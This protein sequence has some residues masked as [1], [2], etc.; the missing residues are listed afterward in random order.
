MNVFMPMRIIESSAALKRVAGE[1]IITLV[2]HS[3]QLTRHDTLWLVVN[4]SAEKEIKRIS[5]TYKEVCDVK[6]IA[7]PFLT[8]GP[9][10]TVMTGLSRFTDEELKRKVVCID[11]DSLHQD[12]IL[13]LFRKEKTDNMLFY[14][15]TQS[16]KYSYITLDEKVAASGKATV[17]N[18][19]EKDPISN[20]ALSG[21][22]AFKSARLL[23]EY[24][25][26]SIERDQLWISQLCQLM[27][28]DGHT[29]RGRPVTHF[30]D[31]ALPEQRESFAQ[32]LAEGANIIP[33]PLKIAVRLESLL[34][35]DYDADLSDA[36]PNHT[37][38]AKVQKLKAMGHSIVIITGRKQSTDM[39]KTIA[40]GNLTLEQIK[41]FKIPFDEI[42][43]GQPSFDMLLTS[44]DTMSDLGIEFDLKQPHD[45]VKPRSFN[46]VD[47][48]SE[49]AVQKT[50]KST[51]LDGEVHFYRN[52]PSD[53]IGYF[54]K[55]IESRSNGLYT[56]L[57]MSRVQGTP[58]TNLCISHCFSKRHLNMLL[59]ALRDIH[60]SKA[61]VALSKDKKVNVYVNY[62]SKVRKRF[63]EHRELY[64]QLY[65]QQETQKMY[66]RIYAHLLEFE[67][68]T[69]AIEAPCI[70][71]DPVFS[72]V[73]DTDGSIILLDMRGKIGKTLTIAGDAHYDLAKV[74]QCLYGYDFVLQGLSVTQRDKKYLGPLRKAYF[75]YVL[76]NYKTTRSNLLWI[77]ASHY[78]SLIPL[79]T[80][81]PKQIRYMG[82]C[83]D[84]LA[85]INKIE[86]KMK[87]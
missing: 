8:R 38:I 2:L 51:I 49:H 34:I 14:F 30:Y 46:R 9:V 55:Y 63:H 7:V 75:S 77:T 6:V 56:S 23:Q 58:L 21:A 47:F 61:A 5:T 20:M 74:L 10:E 32:S 44:N 57:V 76:K 48:I 39:L 18:I 27:I 87:V 26:V 24:C 3:L 11:S 66:E 62:A 68:Q 54:P 79:H 33:K 73:L 19:K 82:L 69:Q 22:Y 35:R 52:I 67:K 41:K 80:E 86:E 12:N 17:K 40:M 36:L 81:R 28:Q 31:L 83:Q 85:D 16:S 37:E 84:V 43:F 42:Y 29:F 53:V 13:L 45:A 70:H 60:N 71:G 4:K 50:S 72:N 78:F 15:N 65:G 64:S 1:K 59:K 25:K